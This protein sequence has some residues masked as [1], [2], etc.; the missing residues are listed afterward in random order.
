MGIDIKC[1]AIVAE[2]ALESYFCG[3][4][5]L[6]I[7]GHSLAVAEKDVETNSLTRETRND[8]VL[9]V[10]NLDVINGLSEHRLNECATDAFVLHDRSEH[11]AVC[12][13][14]FVPALN[15]HR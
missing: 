14:E 15:R 13:S 10:V 4:L 2:P 7:I 5:H 8:A 6:D 12:N 3:I 11:K 1:G 9:T